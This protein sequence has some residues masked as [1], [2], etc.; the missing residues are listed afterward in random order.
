M[1]AVDGGE[2]ARTELALAD[3][4]DGARSGARVDDFDLH[5][6]AAFLVAHPRHAG[7][8]QDHD[9]GQRVADQRPGGNVRSA[10]VARPRLVA[11]DAGAPQPR[12]RNDD[13]GDQQGNEQLAMHARRI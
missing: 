11:P 1:A 9:R 2:F 13:R 4:V 5:D 6:P 10:L 8:G 12:E 3:L 7:G